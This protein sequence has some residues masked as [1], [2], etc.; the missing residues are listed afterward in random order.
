MLLALSVAPLG[1]RTSLG[2]GM[3]SGVGAARRRRGARSRRSEVRK[4][5]VC[6]VC[7]W[8]ILLRGMRSG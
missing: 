5:V 7:R 4:E 6:M 1:T 3:A 2:S 8:L